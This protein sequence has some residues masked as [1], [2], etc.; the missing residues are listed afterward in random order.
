[1]KTSSKS[2]RANELLIDVAEY[3]FTEWLVRRGVFSAF[4]ANYERSFSPYRSFKDRL[5]SHIRHSL[6][7]S[8]FGLSH[9]VTSSFLFCST[10]EGTKF[11]NKQSAAWERF[12]AE[13]QLK[14]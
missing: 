10:P 4:K 2:V 1:M 3:A 13:F 8:G 14:L 6:Q 12:C 9:L 11:W 5:R 7:G